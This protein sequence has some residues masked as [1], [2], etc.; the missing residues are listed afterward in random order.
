MQAHL[1]INISV[2]KEKSTEKDL[3]LVSRE[4]LI[5]FIMY[6]DFTIKS[7]APNRRREAGVGVGWGKAALRSRRRGE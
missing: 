7:Q 4:S 6:V 1:V 5:M 2:E 3:G